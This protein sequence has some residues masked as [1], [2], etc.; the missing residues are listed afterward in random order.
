MYISRQSV[1]EYHD[2]WS[3]N[4]VINWDNVWKSPSVASHPRSPLT[5]RLINE[6]CG[7]DKTRHLRADHVEANQGD[8]NP[9]KKKEGYV[10]ASQLIRSTL[11]NSIKEKDLRAT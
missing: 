7:R 3:R 4:L 5:S 8:P 6:S 11:E 2:L 10:F 9:R 1:T